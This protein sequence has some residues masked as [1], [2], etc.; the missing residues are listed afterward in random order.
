[1]GLPSRQP[2]LDRR[3]A[4]LLAPNR[5]RSLQLVRTSHEAR[6][7]LRRRAPHDRKLFTA[8]PGRTD[9]ARLGHDRSTQAGRGRSRRSRN[10]SA[11]ARL[12]TA[13]V[14]KHERSESP[15]KQR[16]RTCHRARLNFKCDK[17]FPFSPLATLCIS[18][19]GVEGG[20]G[21]CRRRGGVVW[22][23]SRVGLD[24][25]VGPRRE[26]EPSRRRGW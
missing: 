5:R 13:K 8:R 4:L 24:V 19:R 1:M 14:S 18:R 12:A 11:S 15:S 9:N 20:R 2:C 23:G 6:T 17:F 25:D 10:N 26:G 16:E 21:V 3:P 22:L 7:G